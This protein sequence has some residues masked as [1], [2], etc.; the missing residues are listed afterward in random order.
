M[1]KENFLEFHL[2]VKKVEQ[3]REKFE[4]DFAVCPGYDRLAFEAGKYSVHI[5][6]QIDELAEALG[7]TV[8]VFG[9]DDFYK[10][11]V[12]DEVLYFTLNK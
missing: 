2:N 10:G 1:N 3:A 4:E 9:I 12:Y 8:E 5:H 7:Q 11:F 6:R